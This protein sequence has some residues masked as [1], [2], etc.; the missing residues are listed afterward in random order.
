VTGRGKFVPGLSSS[1]P[2]V[3]LRRQRVSFASSRARH[4]LSPA[5]VE[6]LLRARS[7]RCWACGRA[8][9]ELL[10][11]DGTPWQVDHDHERARSHPHPDSVGCRA[12]FRGMLCRPCNSALGF[13]ED[14]SSRL[15]LLADY[16]DG[17]R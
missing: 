13:A 5:E 10:G 7:Y 15:R 14:S 17:A 16:L 6:F 11:P 8:G 9:S 12:C 4:G 2:V 1:R 3:G